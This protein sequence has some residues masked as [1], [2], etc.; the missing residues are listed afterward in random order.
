MKTYKLKRVKAS[1]GMNSH[2]KWIDEIS[3]KFVYSNDDVLGNKFYSTQG[4]GIDTI[5]YPS[6][7]EAIK[8]GI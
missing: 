4:E 3:G 2:R 7:T 1:Q 8:G 5:W 6:P